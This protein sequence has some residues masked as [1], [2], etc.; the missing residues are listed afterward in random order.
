MAIHIPD[1][2]LLDLTVRIEKIAAQYPD[3]HI[4]MSSDVSSLCNSGFVIVRNTPW[5]IRFL[6]RWWD[7]RNISGVLNDQVLIQNITKVKYTQT[8]TT[9][10]TIMC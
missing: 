3:A 10:E 4:I 1:I 5:A 2:L 7:Q 9:H 6:T 8:Y